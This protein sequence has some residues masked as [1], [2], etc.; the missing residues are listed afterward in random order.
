M[1]LIVE[2]L[3]ANG[4]TCCN[5]TKQFKTI[6]ELNIFRNVLNENYKDFLDMIYY[7]DLDKCIPEITM[8]CRDITKADMV[9]NLMVISP[10]TFIFISKDEITF[11]KFNDFA[12]KTIDLYKFFKN[13]ND[14]PTSFDDV[15]RDVDSDSESDNG[16]DIRYQFE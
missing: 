16:V 7:I 12:K 6:E 15:D 14:N 1:E 8:F 3:K 11:E 10:F 4:I 9:N 5:Y 2:N 13:A